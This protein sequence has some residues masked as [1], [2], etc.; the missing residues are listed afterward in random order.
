[1]ELRSWGMRKG[2]TRIW[3]VALSHAGLVGGAPTRKTAP[4]NG[5]DDRKACI[6]PETL[7]AW[8]RSITAACTSRA[9]RAAPIRRRSRLRHLGHP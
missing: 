7:P 5:G 1:M 6:Q 2:L 4:Q 9:Q 8:S 3:S